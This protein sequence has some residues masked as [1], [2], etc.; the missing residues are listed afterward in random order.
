[1]LLHASPKKVS[2]VK[3]LDLGQSRSFSASG[4]TISRLET[5]PGQPNPVVGRIM[6][7]RL[8]SKELYG[9]GGT[10]HQEHGGRGKE[11]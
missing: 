3:V 8:D 5:R 4:S 2:E 7:D 11:H 9:I 10:G 1:M 6:L